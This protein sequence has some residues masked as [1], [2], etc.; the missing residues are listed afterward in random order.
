MTVDSWIAFSIAES[1]LGEALVERTFHN[2]AKM[3]PIRVNLKVNTKYA[4]GY[5]VTS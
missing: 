3:E 5:V 1:Y 2:C 4:R